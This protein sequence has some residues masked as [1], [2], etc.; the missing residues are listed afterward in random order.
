MDQMHTRKLLLGEYSAFLQIL[1][2]RGVAFEPPFTDAE[3]AKL[4]IPDLKVLVQQVRDLSRTP[5]GNR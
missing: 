1:D 4:P 3:L 5:S 2:Q